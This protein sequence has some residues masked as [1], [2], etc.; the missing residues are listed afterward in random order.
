MPEPKPTGRDEVRSAVLDAAIQLS[1]ETGP[2]ATSLRDVASA[3]NVNLGLLHRHFGNKNELIAAAL[4]QV[5][6]VHAPELIEA[7]GSKNLAKETASVTER[8]SSQAYVRMLAW[9][10]LE[11]AD[12]TQMQRAYPAADALVE[13]LLQDGH[14]AVDARRT[15]AGVYALLLG[16]TLFEPFIATAIGPRGGTDVLTT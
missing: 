16:W 1:A 15:A 7:Y 6:D 5:V 11:G 13:R 10:L 14:S 2:E 12:A 9:A 3:A 8:P 4:Q